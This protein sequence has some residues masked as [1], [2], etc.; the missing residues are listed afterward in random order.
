[1]TPPLETAEELG[2][3]GG[4]RTPPTFSNGGRSEIKLRCGGVAAR[5]MSMN[6]F[7]IIGVIVVVI[8]LLKFLGLY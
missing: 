7:Y 8:V 2:A 5:W 6:I 4:R 1:V 3:I